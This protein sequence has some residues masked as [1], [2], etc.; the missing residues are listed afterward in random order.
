MLVRSDTQFYTIL[1]SVVSKP[2]KHQTSFRVQIV[3]IV[4]IVHI[5]NIAKKG[6]VPPLLLSL[7]VAMG[8][9]DASFVNYYVP[10]KP[11]HKEQFVYLSYL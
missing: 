4:H 6:T 7:Q 2:F 11:Y 1:T 10:T 8:I 5:V 9:W 3:H